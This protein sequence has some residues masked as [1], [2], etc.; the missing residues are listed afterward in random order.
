[1]LSLL[2]LFFGGLLKP[3]NR[4]AEKTTLALRGGAL[5][6]ADYLIYNI[7]EIDCNKKVTKKLIAAKM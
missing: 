5:L 7:S 4:R 6:D 3:K 1:V 2:L